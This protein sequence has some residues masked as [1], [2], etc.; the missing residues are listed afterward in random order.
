MSLRYCI[1][2]GLRIIRFRVIHEMSWLAGGVQDSDAGEADAPLACHVLPIQRIS[3][4]S[5]E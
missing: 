5:V 3:P 4:L 2:Q 1:P